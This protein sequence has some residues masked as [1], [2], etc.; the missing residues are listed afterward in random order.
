MRAGE[1]SPK[2]PDETL[3]TQTFKAV[4]DATVA[5][6]PY[7]GDYNMAL[8]NNDMSAAKK[9]KAANN[10]DNL[11]KMERDTG[12]YPKQIGTYLPNSQNFSKGFATE[13]PTE[14][15]MYSHSRFN[16]SHVNFRAASQYK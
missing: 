7:G 1:S 2:K 10:V 13:K 5:A 8:V 9:I 11:A 3:Q 15:I 4:H 14:S 12:L 16:T 6:L